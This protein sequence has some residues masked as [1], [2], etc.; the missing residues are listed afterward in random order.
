MFVKSSKLRH[1]TVTLINVKASYKRKS[2]YNLKYL[3]S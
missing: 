2:N 1:F 3:L